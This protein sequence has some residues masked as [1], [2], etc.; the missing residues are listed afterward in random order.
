MNGIN[1]LNTERLITFSN[2]SL[3][4]ILLRNIL[5][6]KLLVEDAD[7]E[8]CQLLENLNNA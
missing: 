1:V 7:E 2:Y 6:G 3:P 8:Q 4:I 5:E